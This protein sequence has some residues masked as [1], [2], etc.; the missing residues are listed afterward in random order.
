MNKQEFKL[1]M[2]GLCKYFNRQI[3]TTTLERWYEPLKFLDAEVFAGAVKDFASPNGESS[4]PENPPQK[5]ML[6]AQ[7]HLAVLRNR[8]AREDEEEMKATY[9]STWKPGDKTPDEWL[10]EIRLLIRGID[11]ARDEN[12]VMKKER[13]EKEAEERKDALRKILADRVLEEGHDA[14]F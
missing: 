6:Y 14:P 12:F 13:T 1:G 8:Q 4:W 11:M 9:R 5:I 10:H 2:M 3:P 7:P